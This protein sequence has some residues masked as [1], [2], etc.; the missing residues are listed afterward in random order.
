MNGL[1][2]LVFIDDN[3]DIIEAFKD[4]F[5]SQDYV[6]RCFECGAEAI[7][8]IKTDD[9]IFL[10]ITDL[11]MPKMDGFEVYQKLKGEGL[12]RFPIYLLS[13]H[14]DEEMKSKAKEIGFDFVL[15][16]PFDPNTLE[17]KIRESLE[18]SKR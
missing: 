15:E 16:K 17:M 2:T 14:I 11:K 4:F 3:E 1:K 6:I 12:I 9:T 8:Y 10:L 13:G 18:L 5:E 7:D